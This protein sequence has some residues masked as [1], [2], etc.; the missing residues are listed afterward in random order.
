MTIRHRMYF[1]GFAIA[2][3]FSSMAT[4]IWF[5][6]TKIRAAQNTAL[7]LQQGVSFLQLTLRGVNES[8]LT[9]GA[10]ASV[11]IAREGL[12]HF[13]EAY[14]K[15]LLLTKAR[16]DLYAFLEDEW[17]ASWKDARDKIESFLNESEAFD[18]NDVKKMIAIGTLIDR[19]GKLADALNAMAEVSEE[20]AVA[21]EQAALR[22][23]AIGMVAV[24]V[25]IVGLF[26]WLTRLILRPLARL[27]QFIGHV[28]SSRDLS[29]RMT[30]TSNDEL[31]EI[32]HAAN[33]LLERFH[34]VL[35]ELR[36]ATGD[37]AQQ[38]KQL[39]QVSE[40]TLHGVA[41]QRDDTARLAD[42]VVRV[43][44]LAVGTAERAVSAA[45]AVTGA[46]GNVNAN[47]IIIRSAAASIN[48]LAQRVERSSVLLIDL[49]SKGESIG[50]IVDVIKSIAEQTNL[51]ALNAAIEAARAGDQG[52]GFAVVADEVRTLATR[53]Q[54]STAEIQTMIEALQAGTIAVTEVMKDA[55]SKADS[56][57]ASTAAVVESLVN[58]AGAIQR[59]ADQGVRIARDA[60]HQNQEL[61]SIANGLRNIGKVCDETAENSGATLRVGH[62]L[63]AT[64][65]RVE[66]LAEQFRI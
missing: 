36:T 19:T 54:Q 37:L 25:V 35:R 2:L 38:S 61:T 10:S 22:T 53:T 13:E 27:V 30:N 18:F 40:S 58:V 5:Q 57:V 60:E 56:S 23:A 47:Q 21:F 14:A 6:Y 55:K 52:R 43:V 1:T 46:H 44:D 42:A 8:A 50:R 33:Q 20:E 51:L 12:A 49:N 9:K 39:G 48:D 65:A 11:A 34:A 59:A 66:Q 3:L 32:G 62:A 28:A 45:E 64:A 15:L 16:P 17:L 41:G 31:G 4:V 24:G 26:F 29:A 63:V 7:S